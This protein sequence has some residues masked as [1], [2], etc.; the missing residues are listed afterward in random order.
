MYPPFEIGHRA[1]LSDMQP[2]GV[3]ITLKTLSQTP[4]L[5]EVISLLK[6]YSRFSLMGRQVENLFSAEEADTIIQN[7][8]GLNKL[9][10]AMTGRYFL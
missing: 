6:G 7:A 9:Q 3:P 5:F 2:L 4:K 10:R 1:S 8:M